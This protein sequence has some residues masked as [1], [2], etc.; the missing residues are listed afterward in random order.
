MKSNHSP[1]A[2]ELFLKFQPRFRR[3][4]WKAQCIIDEV[5]YGSRRQQYERCYLYPLFRG[6][7]APSSVTLHCRGPAM[8]DLRHSDVRPAFKFNPSNPDP[9]RDQL[10]MALNE[11]VE[12]RL[13]K[14]R[15]Y[16]DPDPSGLMFKEWWTTT[17]RSAKF[18][19][20]GPVPYGLE[21]GGRFQVHDWRL[22][23]PP[24]PEQD[25]IRTALELDHENERRDHRTAHYRKEL[26]HQLTQQIKEAA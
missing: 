11:A 16:L 1:L 15:F 10:V 19:A 18:S 6:E 24:G 26:S 12:T 25:A 21:L 3:V 23:I 7:A 22:F 14:I 13:Q 8:F 9:L 4:R 17:V 2:V 5:V 20:A